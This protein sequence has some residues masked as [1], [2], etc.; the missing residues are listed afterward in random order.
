MRGTV[1]E[2][3]PSFLDTCIRPIVHSSPK[4]RCI[5]TLIHRYS[6][7]ISS[8]KL[9]TPR[10]KNTEEEIRLI[11]CRYRLLLLSR[12]LS[13]SRP[14]MRIY[15]YYFFTLGNIKFPTIQLMHVGL[16]RQVVQLQMNNR[17]ERDKG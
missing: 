17:E 1:R 5:L 6:N 3:Y 15:Y 4:F 16:F 8:L 14:V 11:D 12:P 7:K 13:F 2:S 9:R 10:R